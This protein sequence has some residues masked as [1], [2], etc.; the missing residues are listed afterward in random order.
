MIKN[1]FSLSI[2]LLI[3]QSLPAQVGINTTTP[4]PKSALDVNST[5]QGFLPPRM[6]TTQRNAISSP[7]PAGLLIWCLDCGVSGQVQVFDGITWKD[8]AGGNATSFMCGTSLVTFNYNGSTVTF[9][10][11]L[12]PT[13]NRC[14]LDRNLGASQV[15]T[16]STDAAAYGDLFQWGR[17]SDGHQARSS[18]TTNIVS[19]T[20]TPEHGDFILTEDVSGDWRSPQNSSLWQGVNGINN[21][22]PYGYRIP[23]TQEFNAELGS[24]GSDNS[25]GAFSSPLKLTAGGA[26]TTG[27]GSIYDLNNVGHYWAST[28]TFDLLYSNLLFFASNGASVTSNTRAEAHSVRCIKD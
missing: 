8:M 9:G 14:W 6:T 25:G 23:T 13:T 27:D 1:L 5:T 11:V 7:I 4:H 20:D 3:F 18:N 17:R 15:A 24:W 21:P 22:C 16:S 12:N 28:V 10:T 19:T 26:R 2:L